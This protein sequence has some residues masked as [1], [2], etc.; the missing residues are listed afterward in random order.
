MNK[1]TFLPFRVADNAIEYINT[2]YVLKATYTKTHDSHA[3]IV[4]LITG[5]MLTYVVDSN[6]DDQEVLQQWLEFLGE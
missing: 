6:S 1:S 2:N 3:L 4:K 5:A